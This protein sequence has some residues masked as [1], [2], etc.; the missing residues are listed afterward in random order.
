MDNHKF[1]IYSAEEPMKLLRKKFNQGE[2]LYKAVPDSVSCVE[3]S[4]DVSYVRFVMEQAYSGY[5]YYDKSQFD[6]AF[7]AMEDAVNSCS[8]HVPVNDLIDLIA[9]HLSFICDGHL[10]LTAKDYGRG[11]YRKTQTYV[12]DLLLEEIDGRYVDAASGK[13][14][15]PGDDIRLF[16][17]VSPSRHS[18]FLVGVRSKETT[19]EIDLTVGSE[20]R[21]VPVHRIKSK[22]P[23]EDS[24]IQENYDGDI[25]YITC[26]TF[27]G[28]AEADIRKCYEIGE[29]CRD[30][31]HVVWDLSNNLGGNSEFPKQFLIGLNG[32]CADMGKVLELQSTLVYAKEHGEIREVPYCLKSD[33][34]VKAT[35]NSLFTGTLHVI[36]NDGVASSGESA[37]V[38]AAAM[39]N[40][41]FYGCNSLGIG[42]FGDLCIYYLPNSKITFW[43][44]QKVFDNSI[45]ETIGF[46]PNIWIDSNDIIPLVTRHIQ[47]Y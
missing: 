15:L 45:E 40:V 4:E 3:A 41:V 26:S 6:S 34:D 20:R 2:S 14:V 11:F 8:T 5:T 47:K 25:A 18:A 22:A 28:D 30:Y 24:L 9:D 27:V 38:M 44:P 43:C 23:V 32:G 12:S 46:E 36:I 29:K 42:K 19:T 16:P 21:T 7:T 10:A 1:L 13:T 17:T 39:K 37:I 31:R 33:S 35:G